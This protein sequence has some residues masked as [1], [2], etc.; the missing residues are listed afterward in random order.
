[1]AVC[2]GPRRHFVCYSCRTLAEQGASISSLESTAPVP[3]ALPPIGSLA[4]SDVVASGALPGAGHGRR[5]A[6]VGAL[7]R[8]CR[9]RQW[10][11]NLLV[12]AA[13]AAAGVLFQPGVL[14]RVALAFAAFCLLSSATYLL[15]DVRD[16][17]EDRLHPIKRFRPVAAGEL[18]PRAALRAAV[19]IGAAGLLLAGVV[20]P[21]LGLI[22]VIYLLV[23][24]CYSL[25]WRH[26]AGAD[27]LAVASGFVLRGLAGGAAVDVPVSRWFV[28]VTSAGALF[29]VAGK[30]YAELRASGS[31]RATR[32]TLRR[33][34]E[35]QLAAALWLAAL[36]SLAAYCMW[37]IRRTEHGPVPWNELTVLPF[38]LWL[39]RYAGLLRGGRGEAPE[40]LVLGDRV[41]LLL[42]AAWI[43]LF[44]CGVYVGR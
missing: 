28:L 16:R 31:A 25:W 41:L 12:G 8:S 13:P 14:Y 23:T 1:M 10:V 5:A 20:R 6:A 32:E 29:V 7:L 33:Y 39:G 44:A 37:A 43:A 15:N 36:V 40:A 2:S 19:V 21:A 27:I 3:N 18:S 11:K 22:G 4:D 34:S 42:S 38:T 35:R 17:G 26:V 24:G 30:R 9:P